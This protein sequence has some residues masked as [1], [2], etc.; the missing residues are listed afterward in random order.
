MQGRERFQSAGPREV[1]GVLGTHV[2]QLERA[3][4]R[5]GQAIVTAG[6]G[7]D[8]DGLALGFHP[9]PLHLIV[10]IALLRLAAVDHEVVKQVVVARALPDLR[11]HDDRTVETGHLEGSRRAGQHVEVVVSGDHIAPPGFLHVPLQLDAQRAVV[12]KA[13]QPAVDLARLKQKPTPLTQR[14]QLVHVHGGDSSSNETRIVSSHTAK[15]YPAARVGVYGIVAAVDEATKLD[16]VLQYGNERSRESVPIASCVERKAPGRNKPL[17][18]DAGVDAAGRRRPVLLYDVVLGR[19]GLA[20]GRH[21]G[22]RLAAYRDRNWHD[23]VRVFRD[24]AQF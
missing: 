3:L 7:G 13:V 18:H 6:L 1:F 17:A 9:A 2:E 23:G 11:V 24:R 19:R 16:I 22:I 14:Y 12:P 8:K 21:Y 10:A 15:V 5:C 20:D 4:L